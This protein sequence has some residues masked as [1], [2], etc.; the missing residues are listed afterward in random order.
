M[1]EPKAP[2]NARFLENEVLKSITQKPSQSDFDKHINEMY[3]DVAKRRAAMRSEGEN[4]DISRHS[5]DRSASHLRRFLTEHYAAQADLLNRTLFCEFP[6]GSLNA[7]TVAVSS[8]FLVLIN[9]G[10]SPFLRQVCEVI[11]RFERDSEGSI[12]PTEE[13]ISILADIFYAYI[14]YGSSLAGPALLSGGESGL[15]AGTL[16]MACWHFVLCHEYGHIAAGHLEA[17]GSRNMLPTPKGKVAVLSRQQEEEFQADAIGYKISLETP[18]LKTIDTS[19][20]DRVLDGRFSGEDF[21]KAMRLKSALAAPYIFFSI[22]LVLEEIWSRSAKPSDDNALVQTHPPAKERIR[23]LAPVLFSLDVRHRS[24][25]SFGGK[26]G[27]IREE[28]AA[29]VCDRLHR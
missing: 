4:P 10:I 26:L 22:V 21:A 12:H 29:L 23:G 27:S 6:T 5:L 24:F 8:G 25:A 1:T 11:V 7:E 18:S 13:T 16:A 19:T 9:S 15:L 17:D 3:A 2:D 28:I 20:L 14:S